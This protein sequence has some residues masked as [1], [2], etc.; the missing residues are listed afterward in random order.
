[1]LHRIVESSRKFAYLPKFDAYQVCFAV[2][3]HS[4]FNWH[5]CTRC[6]VDKSDYANYAS[7]TRRLLR[8]NREKLK[9]LGIDCMRVGPTHIFALPKQANVGDMGVIAE[10]TDIEFLADGRAHLQARP[11]HCCQFGPF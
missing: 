4:D 11:R 9:R 7:S 8:F 6:P 1:M 3:I 10:I 5:P 2:P